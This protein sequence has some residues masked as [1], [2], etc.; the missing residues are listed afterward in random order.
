MKLIEFLE[1]HVLFMICSPA[2]LEH[3]AVVSFVS[4]SVMSAIEETQKPPEAVQL[5][6]LLQMKRKDLISIGATVPRV[7]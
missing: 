1:P 4:L 7:C 6:L 5:F 2:D 3:V